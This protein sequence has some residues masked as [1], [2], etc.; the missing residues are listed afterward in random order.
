MRKILVTT[1]V[2]FSLACLMPAPIALAVEG[3]MDT[4]AAQT[5]PVAPAEPVAPAASVAPVAPSGSMH[6]I[7]LG[8]NYWKAIN[9]IGEE[10]SSD[11]LSYILSY[12]YAPVWFVK[13]GTNLE[14]FPDLAGSSNPV[15]APEVFVTVGGL[16]YCG[17]GIGIYYHE[18]DW[19]DAP[20]YMFRAGLDI[21]VLPR[22]YL[23]LNANYRFNDWNTLGWSDMDS[24]TIR[25]GAAVRFAL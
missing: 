2:A 21:P 4:P 3:A 25:L 16:F 22:L 24:D 15:L 9:H 6:R 19:G 23:D 7:G 18:G 8:V 13:V 1:A 11:G 17:V 20:F 10:F 14:L 5:A 12:Q